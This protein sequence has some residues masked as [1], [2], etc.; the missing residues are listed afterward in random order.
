M[1]DSP[2]TEW[3]GLPEE[4]RL[5]RFMS[6]S[7]DAVKR[8]VIAY[9]LA[10][11]ESAYLPN[12]AGDLLGFHVGISDDD[13]RSLDDTFEKTN[14]YLADCAG[15]GPGTR[16]LDAGCGVGGSSL[17]LAQHRGALVTGISIVGRQVELARR[18][19][20][21]RGVDHL[22][23]FHERDMLDTGFDPS[24][25]DVIWN[26]QAVSHV[27]DIDACVAHF[28]ALLRDGG[29]LSSFD[30]HRGKVEHQETERIACEG[31]AL[32]PLRTAEELE[33]VLLRHDF[34]QVETRDLGERARNT[35]QVLEARASRSLLRIR[36]ESKLAGI[37]APPLYEGHVRA[38]LAFVEGMRLGSQALLHV[39]ARRK[40]RTC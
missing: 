30:H 35:V 4:P 12:W 25:F 31:W 32:A 26:L 1:L 13:A 7:S 16:V 36:V 19:A 15:L 2:A 3:R 37:E 33:T 9:Y 17:W 20:A 28:S 40:R 5:A 38:A 11:T 29:V 39:T 8:R 22:A 27:A 34:E 14:A 6:G 23:S 24:S 21:E 10:T 18:Y